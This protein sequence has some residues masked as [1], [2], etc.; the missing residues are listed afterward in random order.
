[1]QARP[2]DLLGSGRRQFPRSLSLLDFWFK[3]SAKA[4]R[5]LMGDG[6]ITVDELYSYVHDRVTE[7]RPQQ[8]PKKVDNIEGRT[9][10]AANVNWTLPSYL[11][12]AVVSPLVGDRQTA[13]EGLDH[14]YRVGNAVVRNRVKHEVRRLADD[15]S[16]SVSAA[17]L[18][19]LTSHET[20]LAPVEIEPTGVDPAPA[21]EVGALSALG[22]PKAGWIDNDLTAIAGAVAPA[23]HTALN[24]Y[25]LS[26]DSQHVIYVGTDNHVHELFIAR[27][28]GWADNDLT[29]IAG[30]VAPAAHTAVHGHRL[31]D[32]SQH[33][34]YVGVDN[35]V[36]E[37]F[38][39]RDAGWAD[40][41]LTA[42][43]GAVAP[44]AHTALNGYPLSDDSQHV[45]YVG[46]DQPLDGLLV[47]TLG[48]LFA[49]Q[50]DLVP[51]HPHPVGSWSSARPVCWRGTRCSTSRG[52]PSRSTA[53]EAL[54]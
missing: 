5:I 48:A 43:A 17:A 38:I 11:R 23:A 2:D 20:E 41:D 34:I 7:Q 24:G 42:I 19:W 49:V 36:H 29:A 26:D 22:D 51:A 6:D 50:A 31:S 33:V 52:A 45:I 46:V 39:A 32:D 25:R 3:G 16:R 14:L 54:L 4:P 28:G 18:V 10:L 47:G 35:H 30:A 40:N 1:M 13:L 53:A 27:G 12:N 44:A 9:V 21:G 8:R 37:L 15:D